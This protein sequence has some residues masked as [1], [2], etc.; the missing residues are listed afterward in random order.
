MKDSDYTNREIDRMFTELK[1]IMLRVEAQTIK[2]NGRVTAL[3]Y[4]KEGIM[5]K[6]I[7]G[8]SVIAFA[9]SIAWFYI[10]KHL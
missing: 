7:G 2:T 5:G 9:W 10:T 8:G 3:E 1:E 6:I 4:W